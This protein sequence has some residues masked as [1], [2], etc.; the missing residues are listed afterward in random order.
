MLICRCAVDLLEP[1]AL[2]RVHCISAAARSLRSLPSGVGLLVGNPNQFSTESS[3]GLRA[4]G[5]RR[6]RPKRKLAGLTVGDV[7]RQSSVGPLEHMS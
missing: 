3:A 6:N 4:S 7:D 1:A 5:V 2:A